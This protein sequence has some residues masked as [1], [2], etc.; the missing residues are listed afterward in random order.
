MLGRVGGQPG[1]ARPFIVNRTQRPGNHEPGLESPF[2]IAL[3]LPGHR[4]ND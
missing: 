2:L 1:T 4:E 3:N